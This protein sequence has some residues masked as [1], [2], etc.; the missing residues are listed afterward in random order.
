[1][2]IATSLLFFASVLAHELAHSLVSMASG[3]PVKSITLFIFGGIA[4][5]GR[6]AEQ[7]GNE[8]KMAAAGP[9][10]SVA[11]CGLFAGIWWLTRGF[12]DHLSAL[13]WWLAVIN[14][15]LAAFNMIPGFPLDGGRVFRAIVWMT[16][17]SYMRATR[18]ATLTGVGVSYLFILAG[19]FMMFFLVGGLFN[20]LW[21]ILIGWFLNGAAKRSYQQTTLRDTLKRFTAKDVMTRDYPTVPRQ[22]TIKELVQGQLLLTRGSWFLVTDGE[23]VEGFLTLHRIKEVPREKWD[24][25]TVGQA[26]MAVSELKAVKPSDDAVS[27]IER[28][29][30][31]HE[32]LVTV[33][34]E[35]RILGVILR[36]DLTQFAFRM[37]S[38]RP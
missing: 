36:D 37:Q 4:H 10:C 32:N 23:R 18:I 16:T 20:G 34:E 15:I 38:L 35:G 27:V 1:V 8:L 21:L 30:E 13:A 28:M 2:G 29:S 22:L 25:T 3:I 33:V 7:P 6:E 11:L 26:M 31:E 9:L 24:I 14:G 19:V 12:S 5:I 17:G